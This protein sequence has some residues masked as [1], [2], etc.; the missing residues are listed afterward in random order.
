MSRSHPRLCTPA[1]DSIHHATALEIQ[2]SDTAA[3]EASVPASVQFLRTLHRCETS[4]LRGQRYFGNCACVHSLQH[5]G[6]ARLISPAQERVQ[7][8]TNQ[9]EDATLCLTK[10]L[11]SHGVLSYQEPFNG[12]REG[13]KEVYMVYQLSMDEWKVRV[14]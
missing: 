8:I 3:K 7:E 12:A 14:R 10:L 1:A 13:L 2:S 11:R 9:E 6:I 5:M 4:R